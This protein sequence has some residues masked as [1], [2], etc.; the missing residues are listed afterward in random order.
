MSG[1]TVYE[2]S[3]IVDEDC[4]H[5]NQ[6]VFLVRWVGYTSQQ[7]TWEPLDNLKDG[8]MEVVREWDRKKK[9]VQKR[10]AKEE[11]LDAAHTRAKSSGQVLDDI[12]TEEDSTHAQSPQTVCN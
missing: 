12:K 5:P 10:M 7:D 1:D 8:A 9:Q 11:N 4:S 2:V 3:H 6:R